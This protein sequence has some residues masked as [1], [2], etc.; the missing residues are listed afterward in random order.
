LGCLLAW[1]GPIS[2]KLGW[3]A[4]ILDNLYSYAWFV[5]F[6]VAAIVYLVLMKLLPPRPAVTE[7]LKTEN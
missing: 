6:G 2:H 4:R 5:G 1:S 7:T 3:S